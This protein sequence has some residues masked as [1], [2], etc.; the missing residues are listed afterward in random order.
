MD[1]VDHAYTPLRSA[2]VGYFFSIIPTQSDSRPLILLDLCLSMISPVN[3][4][5]HLRSFRKILGIF[6]SFAKDTTRTTTLSR[7]NFP[8]A[9]MLRRQSRSC[10]ADQRQ[11]SF[12]CAI[13]R[14]NA[15]F[16]VLN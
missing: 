11:P 1:H 9:Q 16:C 3:V 13:S 2:N 5:A 15:L 4:I 12:L 8:L 10:C 7:T 14:Q 6:P